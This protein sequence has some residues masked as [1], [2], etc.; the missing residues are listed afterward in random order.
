V[1]PSSAAEPSEPRR[2]GLPGSRR[3]W[4]GALLA[5][6]GVLLAWAGYAAL[7]AREDLLAARAALTDVDTDDTSSPALR[8][9]VDAAAAHTARAAD[10][11][12]A[13]GPSLVASVPLLGRSLAAQRD[14]AVAADALVQGGRRLLPLVEELDVDGG[15]LDPEAL[16]RLSQAATAADRLAADSAE[17]LART[18]LGLTPSTVGS[19]V[20]QARAELLPAAAGLRAAEG[21]LAGERSRTLVIGL[22]N[23]AEARGA[24]G[25]VA[26]FAV[27]RFEDG[28]VAVE[29][30]RDV[31]TV[32]ATPDEAVRVPASADF[33][34]RWGPYLADTKLWKNVAMSPHAPDSAAVLCEVV[35]LRPAVDC[36]GAVLLD[37][38]ALAEVMSLSGPV[39]LGDE[40]LAGPELVDA[41]LI[42]A[43]AD[44]EELGQAPAERRAGLLAA[45]DAALADLLSARLTGVPALRLLGDLAAGRHLAVWSSVADE[46]ADLL[47]AGAA[48]SA[49]PEGAD[50]S[51]VSLNQISAGKLDV[52]LRRSLAV[53][54]E[55][56]PEQAV[57]EQRVVLELDHPPGLPAYVLGVR[58][59]RLDELVDLGLA[60][61]AREVSLLR[62]GVPE[63]FELVR[64]DRG[65]SRAAF[66]LSMR[67]PERVELVLRYSTPVTD[68]RYRLRLLPQPLARDA[69]LRLRVGAAEG[70]RLTEPDVVVDGPLDRVV[71]VEVQVA[72]PSWWDRPVELP[73]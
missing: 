47:R 58:G 24:G 73:F 23:N 63:P 10:L 72:R 46:Q 38:R 49:D 55:V 68:G 15:R 25:Y 28:Q 26:S 41:L 44:A 27:A 36:D 30:F 51:L 22:M 12:T 11:L 64:G 14:V 62:D 69:E 65:S 1:T 8:A 5:L 42:D 33:T 34:R 70:A 37:V 18:P 57:V 9:A 66:V 60:A 32:A 54:V 31:N 17:Q 67:S 53:E 50:L 16:R 43:Y 35:R 29:G 3:T 21:L 2:R 71:D 45:A 20:E 61:D 52:Y 48:G 39:Q 7:Q 13:P 59:G 6:A 56:G 40:E 19:A 4:A